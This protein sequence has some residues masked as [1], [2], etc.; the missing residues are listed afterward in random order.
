MNTIKCQLEEGPDNRCCCQCRN[1]IHTFGVDL[2]QIGWS[3]ILFM[4]D[5]NPIIIFNPEQHSVGCGGFDEEYEDNGWDW[6]V[7]RLD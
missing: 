2:K 5:P 4:A 6:P 7:E 1:L 3:C